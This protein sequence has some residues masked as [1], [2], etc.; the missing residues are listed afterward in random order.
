MLRRINAQRD[1]GAGALVSSGDPTAALVGREL[2]YPPP[3]APDPDAEAWTARIEAWRERLMAREGVVQCAVGRPRFG[4]Q[5]SF[6]ISVARLASEVSAGAE[7]GTV[8]LR[9]TRALRPTSCVEIG[10]AAGFSAAYSAA[11]LELAGSGRLVCIEASADCAGI[12]R[13]T[14]SELGL[15]RADVLQGRGAERL[16]DVVEKTGPLQLAFLDDDHRRRGTIDMAGQLLD[17]LSPGGVLLIDNVHH[18][19]GMRWA[20][21]A[22]SGDSRLS[23]AVDCGGIGVC[24]RAA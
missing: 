20:W 21:S 15:Q 8:M 22:V 14:F 6:S 4:R 24:V 19:L 9:L 18:S 11:G 1:A 10:S 12:T 23:T 2:R 3:H 16:P 7:W 17:A 13:E 5:R